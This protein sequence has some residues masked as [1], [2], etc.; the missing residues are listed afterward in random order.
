MKRWYIVAGT[1]VLGPYRT[2]EIAEIM[3]IEGDEIAYMTAEEADGSPDHFIWHEG[4]TLEIPI[5]V[6]PTIEPGT[7]VSRGMLQTKRKASS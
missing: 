3:Q 1:L 6:Q 2:K 5:V 7:Q 4:D